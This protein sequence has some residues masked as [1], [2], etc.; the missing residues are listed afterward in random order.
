MVCA[1][2]DDVR[3]HLPAD[4]PLVVTGNPA[5]PGFEQLFRAM[6][7]K[8]ATESRPNGKSGCQKRLVVIGGV[9]GAHSLNESMPVALQ[10]LGKRLH[11]WQIV[12][13]T[14]E[15]HL[16]DTLHR[17][18]NADVDALVVSFIDELAP[19]LFQSHLV[20]CRAGGTT[21][22][23]LA[24]AGVPAV[25]VPYSRYAEAYQL[26]NADVAVTAHAATMIDEVALEAPLDEA[27][28]DHI[29]PLLADDVRRTAMAANMRSL[30]RPDAASLVTDT[31]RI[32]LGAS[33]TGSIRLA[34]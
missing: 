1:G 20:V 14:G 34:A 8:S 16:Q 2:F 33:A 7:A 18:R 6:N 24:L 31:I 9:G 26:A 28:V 25:F 30:A 19:L 17:Y 12:H 29:A 11:G 21:L 10:R 22:S 5:R 27:L 4:T 3:A 13:Q 15:G 23:E 32:I